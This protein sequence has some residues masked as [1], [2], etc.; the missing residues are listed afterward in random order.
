MRGAL[1][2]K[3]IDGNESTV[4]NSRSMRIIK[5]IMFSVILLTLCESGKLT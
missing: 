4:Y 5:S 3:E 2:R 1:R